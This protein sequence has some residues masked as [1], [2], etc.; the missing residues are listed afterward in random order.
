MKNLCLMFLIGAATAFGQTN[1]GTITGTVYD[2]QQAVMAGVKI[3]ATN[4]ATN[5]AQSTMSSSAG[6]YTIPSLEPGSYNLTADFAGFKRLSQGPVAVATSQTVSVNLQMAVGSGATESIMVTAEVPIMQQATSTIQYGINMKQMDELPLANQSALQVLTLLP[7]VI[8]DPG[9]EQAA[10]TTQVTTPG[11]GMSVSGSPMGTVQYLADGVSNTSMYFGRIS[12]SFSSDA[13]AEVAVQQNSY[14]AEFGRVGGGIVSM[15]TRSGSNQF[16]GTLFSF[17]QNDDLNAAPWQNSFRKKGMVRYWRGG[18]DIGGPIE[19]PK[20]YSGRNRTFFFVSYEPLRQYTQISSFS[21]MATAAERQGD[22]SH[23]VYNALANQPIEIFQQYTADPSGTGFT[24]KRIS[25]PANTAFPQFANNIIPKSLISPIGQKILML[26]PEPNMPLNSLGQNFSVMRN[27][28]NTDDRYSFKVDHSLNSNNRLSFRFSQA[29]TKGVRFF[30]GGLAEQVPTDSSTGTNAALSDTAILGS[31]KVNELRLGFNRSN[32]ARRQTDQQL[33]VDGFAQFGFPSYLTK[34]MPQ[35]L[36]GDAQTQAIASDPGNYE[37]DNFFQL[38]D[39]LSWT[40]GKHNI[41]FGFDFQAP[42]QDLVNY[43]NVGGSWTFASNYTNIG[44]GNT[45]T[46]LG[47]PNAQTGFGFATLL[48]GFPTSVSIAPAVIPYQYRWKYYAGFVQDDFKA[49]SNL[50][51]NLGLRYQVEVPRSEKHGMQGYFVNQLITLPS[52][53]PQQGYIQLD[54]LNGA[55]NT[56]WPTRYNNFE[57]RVG[58][59]YKLPSLGKVGVVLRGAYAIAHIPTNGLFSSPIPDLSPKASQL[60]TNGAANGGQVQMDSNPLV[61]PTGGLV[62]PSNGQLTNLTNLNAIYYLNP[63]VT[64][65]YMQQWNMGFG[66]Q[67]GNNYGLELNYVGNKGTNL[68]GASQIYNSINLAEYAQEYQ[69]GLNM[70]QQIPNPQGIKNANG[71]VI[72]V[73]RQD[74]L[75]PS[76]LLGDITDPLEQGFDSRYNA[77]QASFTKRFSRGFQ[78]NINYTWMKSMDD[79]SCSGQYCGTQLQLWGWGVPQIYGDSHSLEKSVSAFDIPHV[80]RFNY[81]WDLPVGHGKALF[82]S[83]HGPL[84]RVIGNWKLSGNGS[85]QSGAPLQAFASTSAGFPD[86]VGKPRPNV[87]SGVNPII[88]NW[89]AN[90]NN[91]VTQ[92]CP[93]IN[94][95]SIFTPPAFLTLGNAAR[96]LDYIR[97]PHTTMY[98]MAI[99][100]DIPIHDTVR[101]AFRAELYGALNHPYFQ[102]NSNNYGVYQNL[103]YVGV[104]TPTVSSTNINP[105]YVDLGSNIGGNRTIQL[106]LKLYF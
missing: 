8:G 77:L 102:I 64:I 100:K 83:A 15:T 12:L 22:F 28:R 47:I 86:S 95:M 89:E 62:I 75:R 11:A 36:N 104:T 34:G 91:P 3:T 53:A 49:T 72:T 57:P 50:T 20:L 39:T 58:F 26:E 13:I 43:N 24:N 84:D 59:A 105:S 88:P 10:V 27:V 17:S 98:N 54:G 6:A 40:K 94:V 74:S 78:F 106:G 32:I 81:N 42:Q 25:E 71:T 41:K 80:F 23:S 69:A 2:P 67:F 16:H 29:P 90:C 96:V 45:G 18:A 82:G 65:P 60:A 14:S 85:I 7:G 92:T 66:F 37:I 101:L 97:G 9:V 19:I 73:A 52:G 33:S 79:S 103:S 48:L 51:L 70:T 63:N 5:V 61:L 93:Y 46:V 87:I 21:R 55:P 31:N 56:L 35:V 44:S 76:P 4:V 99:L 30:Q 1:A 68:F 38:T